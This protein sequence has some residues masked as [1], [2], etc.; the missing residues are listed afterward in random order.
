MMEISL[1]ALNSKCSHRWRPGWEY[2]MQKF[3]AKRWEK[4]KK[5]GYCNREVEVCQWCGQ[6]R[7]AET[8]EEITAEMVANGD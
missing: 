1:R 4:V 7:D 6:A 2:H 5:L 8:G 3:S